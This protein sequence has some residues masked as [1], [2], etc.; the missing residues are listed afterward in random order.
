MRHCSRKVVYPLV[1]LIGAGLAGC[2]FS[3]I[4]DGTDT[5]VHPKDDHP[6]LPQY[7]PNT[8]YRATGPTPADPL[9][10]PIAFSHYRHATLLGMDCQYCHTEARRSIHA[11]V[12]PVELC[13][14]CHKHVFTDRPEIQKLA[15]VWD[16]GEPI[17]WHK[18]HDLPDYVIFN[19]ARHVGAGLDCTEC[20]GQIPLQGQWPDPNDPSQAVVMKREPSLQM[21]WCLDCH[22]THP[23]ID[24]N[25]GDNADLRRSELKD[26]W[27][28]HK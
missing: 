15:A 6:I 19:H 1:A 18:V 16:S 10:Q 5:S 4:P 8:G 11:G 22:A 21:G 26:C 24:E 28:C 7:G 12:P 3:V 20:H 27:T 13:M 23:S 9:D 14:G 25:Y 2:D 17:V